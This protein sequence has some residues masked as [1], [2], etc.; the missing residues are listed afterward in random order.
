MLNLPPHRYGPKSMLATINRLNMRDYLDEAK[1]ARANGRGLIRR[2][3]VS[4]AVL[5]RA[6][7][8]NSRIVD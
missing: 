2:A 7:F 1:R 5:L 4:Y 6:D 3:C 8:R